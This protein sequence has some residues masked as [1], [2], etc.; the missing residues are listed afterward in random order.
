MNIVSL[1]DSEWKLMNGALGAGSL[2]Q[3]RSL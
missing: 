2:H 3:S 1:S